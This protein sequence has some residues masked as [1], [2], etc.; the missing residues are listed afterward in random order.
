MYNYPGNV[1]ENFVTSKL[2]DELT[3]EI[4]HLKYQPFKTDD[5]RNQ[6]EFEVDIVLYLQG[7]IRSI[8]GYHLSD[9]EAVDIIF[10]LEKP[11]KERALYFLEIHNQGLH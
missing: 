2:I 4:K 11:I 9:F 3:D 10:R 5:Y 7:Y 6:T 1:P 8:H